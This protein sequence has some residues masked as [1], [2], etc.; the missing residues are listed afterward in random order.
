MS[1]KNLF[2]FYYFNIKY[3]NF[4]KKLDI[5]KTNKNI[6]WYNN[7]SFNKFIKKKILNNLAIKHIILTFIK[8]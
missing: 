3:K 5:K 2:Q 4:Y 7:N 6:I 1:Y 8:I